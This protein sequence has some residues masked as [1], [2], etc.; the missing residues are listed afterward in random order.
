[1]IFDSDTRVE[2]DPRGEQRKY[3]AAHEAAPL[4]RA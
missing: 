1:M 2:N 4:R 3:F